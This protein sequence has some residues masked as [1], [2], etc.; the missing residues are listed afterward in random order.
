MSL[1]EKLD[2]MR[3]AASKRIPPDRRAIMHRATA[4]L[5]AS[6]IL[7]RIAAVGQA[8]PAFAGAAHDG[9]TIRSDDLLSRGPIILSF[10]RGHW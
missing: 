5:R 8:M 7:D 4:D 6:G 1:K 9:R 2:A 3:E 10:F